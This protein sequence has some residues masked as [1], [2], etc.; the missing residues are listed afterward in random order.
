MFFGE[1]MSIEGLRKFEEAPSESARKISSVPLVVESLGGTE[2]RMSFRVGDSWCRSSIIELRS[3][4]RLGT[5]ACQFEPSFSFSVVQPPCEL[6]LVVSKGALLQARTGYGRD[7]RRGGNALQ[8]GKTSHPLPLSIRPLG[9]APTECVSVSM[10][11]ARLRELL[12]VSE[13]P[14]AFRTVAESEDPCPLVSHVMTAG[15]FRLLDE[16]LNADVRGMS[17][18]LWHEAKCLELVALM[19]DE[20]A[21]AFR[22]SDPR[23]SAQEI[24]RL[25]RARLCLIEHLGAPP[26]LAELARRAGCSETKLKGGFRTL[27]GTSVF[28]Y[29]RQVRLE[30]ARRL[31][32]KRQLN[33][34]EVAQR[35]GY[36]NPSKFAA[37]FRR[38]FG[39]SPSAL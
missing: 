25:Q 33:V 39:M 5:T 32:L 15:L 12:G 28:A 30:E 23:L 16:I 9:E 20:L 18:Q 26:T 2:Q 6:E 22:A 1:T 19:T 4:V 8:L 37:A 11:T 21:E 24:D 38:Q 7:L 3:G 27:F 13:L 31:L 34:T 10:S 29:L 17:R 36:T 35:V 14:E